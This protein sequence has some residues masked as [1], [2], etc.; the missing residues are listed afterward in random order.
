MADRLAEAVDEA[1]KKEKQ[2]VKEVEKNAL[3]IQQ[4]QELVSEKNNLE[5]RL[6]ETQSV[7]ERLN[8]QLEKDTKDASRLVE[9]NMLR[10][11]EESRLQ[12]EVYISLRHRL[13]CTDS[14]L[15]TQQIIIAL[16]HK[17][18]HFLCQ[19]LSFKV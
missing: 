18:L 7:V 16:R 8:K 4:Q 2:L 12:S 14:I 17:S 10:K 1:V 13:T 11:N 3:L 15:S 5:E 9:E 6:S 19:Y